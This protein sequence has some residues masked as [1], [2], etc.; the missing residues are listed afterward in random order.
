VRVRAGERVLGGAPLA[1]DGSFHLRLPPD[2]PLRVELLDAAGA[3]VAA[4]RDPIWMRP[5]EVRG[6][7]GC[8]DDPQTGPPNVRPAAV[9]RDPVDLGR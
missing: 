4:E 1:E 2:T 5:N 8:H 6:C 9:A 7:V 3:V